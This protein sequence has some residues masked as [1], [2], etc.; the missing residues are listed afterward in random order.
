LL[1]ESGE[2]SDGQCRTEKKVVLYVEQE[3]V[4]KVGTEDS[5]VILYL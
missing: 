3:P 5:A 4:P 2:T 1:G